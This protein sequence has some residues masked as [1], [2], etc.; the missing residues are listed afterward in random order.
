[1]QRMNEGREGIVESIH[2]VESIHHNESIQ[3][4]LNRFNPE[5]DGI[6]YK[7]MGSV[8]KHKVYQIS[9]A[10]EVPNLS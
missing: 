2:Q 6:S 7:Y 1:M 3:W 5:V 10:L 8:Q 4:S 9:A